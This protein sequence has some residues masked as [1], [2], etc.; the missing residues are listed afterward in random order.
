M[1][2]QSY[3]KMPQIQI[4]N[5]TSFFPLIWD[6]TQEK[7]SY[8]NTHLTKKKKFSNTILKTIKFQFFNAQ[9]VI[10]WQMEKERQKKQQQF[11]VVVFI[12][13]VCNSSS[14]SSNGSW[15]N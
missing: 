12:L 7:N 14:T 6:W 1:V 4:N 3:I 9:F 10:V 11:Y 2:F 8:K 5:N 13:N 15:L